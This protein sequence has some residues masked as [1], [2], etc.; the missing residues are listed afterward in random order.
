MKRLIITFALTGISIFTPVF[1]A[2]LACPEFPY[3]RPATGP[4]ALVNCDFHAAY[5]KRIAEITASFG[6]IGG[7]PVIL[8]LGG[9]LVF[10]HNGKTD[11]VDITPD[12]YHQIKTFAHATFAVYA[13]LATQSGLLS[14]DTTSSLRLLQDHLKTAYIALPSLGLK[15]DELLMSEKLENL[16][17]TFINHVLSQKQVDENELLNFF[18]N[19]RPLIALVIKKAAEIELNTLDS[20]VNHWL[21][22]LSSEE[23]KQ[24]GVVV[25]TAHQARAQEISLQYFGKKFGFHYGEGAT[26]EKNFVVIEGKFDENSSLALL[27]R[28]YLDRQAAQVILNDPDGLQRDALGDA[29]KEILSEQKSNK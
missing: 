18:N 1:S 13:I 14:N 24:L 19:A 20:T 27:A 23:K 22:L 5:E 15:E 6:A 29:A 11:T 9:T 21:L 3:F 12:A 26:N 8:N 16:T 4:L 28:H 17:S 10:K 7:R 25:A 2:A